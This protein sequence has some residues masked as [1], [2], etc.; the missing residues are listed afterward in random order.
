MTVTLSI[1]GPDFNAY[2]FLLEA[3]QLPEKIDYWEDEDLQEADNGFF[4][5]F[6]EDNQVGS[7][8]FSLGRFLV[9]NKALLMQ[10]ELYPP[11][12]F[13]DL[14][15]VVTRAELAAKNEL[16]LAFLYI[17]KPRLM[18]LLGEAGIRVFVMREGELE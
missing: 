4:L 18:Q 7:L 2:A 10:K 9:A 5:V 15:I 8:P 12:T 16:N 1:Y 3:K 17:L 13:K 14:S 11:E 6:V